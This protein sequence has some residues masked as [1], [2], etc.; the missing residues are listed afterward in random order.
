MLG[1][2]SPHELESLG[3]IE[4]VSRA[5]QAAAFQDLALFAQRLHLASKPTQLVALVARK[6]VGSKFSAS[7]S[8]VRPERR[9]STS[10]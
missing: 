9:S 8:G 10:R 2:V 7:S 1:L 5:N 4:P 3:G 6:T